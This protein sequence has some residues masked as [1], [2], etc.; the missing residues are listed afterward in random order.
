[1]ILKCKLALESY[2]MPILTPEQHRYMSKAM[3]RRSEEAKITE[4]KMMFASMSH[5]HL[6]FAKH[7]EKKAKAAQSAIS[8]SETISV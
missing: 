5:N 3:K 4:D 8:D 2:A 7:Y 1:M 6:A